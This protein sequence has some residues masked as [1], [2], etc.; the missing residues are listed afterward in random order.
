[1]RAG[2]RFSVGLSVIVIIIQL[3]LPL[4]RALASRPALPDQAASV[5]GQ[6]SVPSR[7]SE[8]E[9]AVIS[10]KDG[11][12][13]ARPPTPSAT[14]PR[15]SATTAPR[16]VSAPLGTGNNNYGQMQRDTDNPQNHPGHHFAGSTNLAVTC[17]GQGWSVAGRFRVNET[18]RAWKYPRPGFEKTKWK[19]RLQSKR[20]HLQPTAPARRR[21]QIHGSSAV[22][23]Q[24]PAILGG[25]KS[26]LDREPLSL[27]GV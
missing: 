24:I 23:I 16:Q 3:M 2:R 4:G 27:T 17:L 11:D 7:P 25:L 26:C 14:L 22:E 9:L 18:A 12:A 5:P 20:G 21:W 6:P 10:V 1:M 8:R 13:L 19:S 15:P